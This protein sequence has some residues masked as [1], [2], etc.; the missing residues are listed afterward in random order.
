[1]AQNDQAYIKLQKHLDRQPVGF[2]ATRSGVELK[3]LIHIFT[4]EEAEIVSFMSYKSEPLKT[5]FDKVRHL[6]ESP[7]KLEK[8]LDRIQKKAAS[9]PK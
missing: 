3:I 7:E 1:M 5:I 8:I 9:N 4:S 6:V 2:P